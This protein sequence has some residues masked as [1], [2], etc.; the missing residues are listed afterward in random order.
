MISKGNSDCHVSNDKYREG[1]ERV[2]GKKEARFV[3]VSEYPAR[4]MVGEREVGSTNWNA[5]IREG[6]ESG[7]LYTHIIV[8]GKAYDTRKLDDCIAVVEALRIKG[9]DINLG[10]GLIDVDGLDVMWGNEE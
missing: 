6:L 5:L 1:W 9:A 10:T 7:E 4:V 3:P 8:S 2:F